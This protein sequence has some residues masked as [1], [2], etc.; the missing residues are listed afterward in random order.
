VRRG[1]LLAAL[2]LAFVAS[3]QPSYPNPPPPPACGTHRKEALFALPPSS[4]VLSA[5]DGAL[6]CIAGQ[7][8]EC[9]QS[10]PST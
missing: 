7:G 8:D 1:P 5:E 2:A 3:C 4:L 6:V 9:D 10:S